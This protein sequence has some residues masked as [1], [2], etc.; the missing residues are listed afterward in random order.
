[1]ADDK[2]TPA[3]VAQLGGFAAA[4]SLGEDGV[5]AR[6]AKGAAVTQERYG[7]ELQ[8]RAAHARWGRL[9]GKDTPLAKRI[10][11]LPPTK[12]STATKE[13]RDRA[14]QWSV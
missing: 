14:A 5:K 12:F 2:L 10:A 8:V 4:R 6:G 3:Q 1:M 13:A 11:A 7:K 9:K